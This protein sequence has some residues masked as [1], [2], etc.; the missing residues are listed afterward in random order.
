MQGTCL[1]AASP[2]ISEHK[3]RDA[4]RR[5]RAAPTTVSGPCSPYRMR[6]RPAYG[7]A[8][9]F[10]NC[11]RSIAALAGVTLVILSHAIMCERVSVLDP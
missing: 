2:C 11:V 5:I 3:P 6:A 1:S 10:W 9:Q 8:N 7:L 4:R